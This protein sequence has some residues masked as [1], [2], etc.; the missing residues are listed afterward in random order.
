[1][2]SKCKVNLL[3]IDCIGS[4]KQIKPYPPDNSPTLN[5]CVCFISHQSTTLVA[6]D[7]EKAYYMV[8][9][10]RLLSIIRTIGFQVN[11]LHFITNFLKLRRIKIRINNTLSQRVNQLQSRNLH[12]LLHQPKPTFSPTI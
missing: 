10:Q 12:L 6:L 5:I 3:T 7:I 11:F 1:M 4:L 8:Y 9:R 2:E